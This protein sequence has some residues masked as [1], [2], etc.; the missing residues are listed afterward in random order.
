MVLRKHQNEVNFLINFCQK[1]LPSASSSVDGVLYILIDFL[2]TVT[3]FH[4]S[5][6]R[7][8]HSLTCPFG[9]GFERNEIYCLIVTASV[10][11]ALLL[12]FGRQ[13]RTSNH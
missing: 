11:A 1:L 12:G 9:F 4:R 2:F 8:P 10:T 5:Q 7:G 6:R 13:V 3:F